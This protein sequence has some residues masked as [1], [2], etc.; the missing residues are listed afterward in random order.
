MHKLPDD[1]DIC[2]KCGSPLLSA[3]QR[4]VT[5]VPLDLD[6][7][8]LSGP[9]PGTRQTESRASTG[10][11]ERK[12]GVTTGK[13]ATNGDS[14]AALQEA[15]EYL[16]SASEHKQLPPRTMAGRPP[17]GRTPP[18]RA[19]TQRKPQPKFNRKALATIVA[20]VVAIIAVSLYFGLKGTPAA[21]ASHS[22]GPG[23]T[24]TTTL[25][26]Q[27][28]GSGE[29]TTGSFTTTAPFKFSYRVACTT[30]LVKPVTFTL[31]RDGKKVDLATSGVG[32][33]VESGTL[34]NFG[35]GGAYAF[36]VD[37]PSPCT[38]TVSGAT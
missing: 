25:L 2:G 37:A 7:D 8:K 28:A 27:F 9:P 4:R 19:G 30:T 14:A 29:S 24:Q 1:V 33:A 10:L 11:H 31:V 20:T 38:W 22:G 26:F 6:P 23:P 34:E 13:I 35:D 17:P 16:E 32:N 18:G 12:V 21:P 36:S 15:L 3:A 5:S